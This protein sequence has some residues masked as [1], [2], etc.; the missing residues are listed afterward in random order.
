MDT[1]RTTRSWNTDVSARVAIRSL[2]LS[3]FQLLR[4][5]SPLLPPQT[6]LMRLPG[7]V[8]L[9][10]AVCSVHCIEGGILSSLERTFS[11]LAQHG[12]QEGG[13]ASPGALKA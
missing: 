8:E 1:I 10:L 3:L 5:C 7:L 9:I 13:A 12:F 4:P 6:K 2:L 11:R